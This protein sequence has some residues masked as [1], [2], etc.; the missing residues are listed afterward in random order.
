[1]LDGTYQSVICFFIPYLTFSPTTF[2]TVSGQD[3]HERGRMGLYIGLPAIIIVNTY[4]LLNTYRWDWL[5]LLLVVLSILLAWF[6]TGVYSA[7]ESSVYFYKAAPQVFGQASFWV[8]TLLTV[9]I[10]LL[11]RFVIKSMQKMYFPYDVD[12][13][14]EQIRQGKFKHLDDEPEPI[15]LESVTPTSTTQV[16]Q[17]ENNIPDNMEPRLS[18]V[19]PMLAP[20]RTHTE[21]QR[22]SYDRIRPSLDRTR[23][24]FEASND[25]TSA[26][27][28]ARVESSHSVTPVRSRVER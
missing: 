21:G 13:I 25:F 3:I 8:V 6:W 26:A 27:M 28:L 16:P 14:R 1:M 23:L 5:I 19:P 10:S 2:L 17:D 7:F 20:T 22:R 15:D 24:S 11:P 4:I 12:I 18:V 9:I